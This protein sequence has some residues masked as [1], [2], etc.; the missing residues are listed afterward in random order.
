[1]GVTE[2]SALG[3]VLGERSAASLKRAF[4][5]TL[6]SD[7]LA[8]YPRR[9]AMRGELT[10]LQGTPL[11][12]PVSIVAEVVSVGERPMR[13]RR[14]SLLEVVIT[15]GTGLI[16]LTFFNQAWRKKDLHPG[17]RG[18]FAGKVGSYRG[19]KQLS[20]P[21]YELFPGDISGEESKK[22]AMTPIPLYPAT[23]TLAS[24]Q[25]SRAV[26]IVLDSLEPVPDPLPDDV[27]AGEGLMAKDRALRLIHQPESPDDWVGARDTLRFHE[28][29]ILQLALLQRRE[30]AR[31]QKTV[32]RVAGKLLAHFDAYTPF[33][34]TDG[35]LAVGEEI[36]R[37]LESGQPMHRLVHGEV[38]S[39]KT[40]VAIRGMLQVAQ[41]GGQSALLAPTEVLATQHFRSIHHTLGTEVASRVRPVLLTGSMSAAEKKKALFQVASG[42][43]LIVVGTHALL[44]DRVQFAD[45][46]LVI[47]DEQHRF[48]V[49]QRNTLRLKGAHPHVLVLTATPIPRTVAMTVFGDLDVSTISRVPEGRHPIDTHVVALDDHPDWYD[50]VWSRAREEIDR[51]RQ[52]FVVCPAIDSGDS[53]EES[54]LPPVEPDSEEAPRPPSVGV[55]QLQKELADMPALSGVTV[56]ILHG[57]LPSED[58]DSVMGGF[59]SGGIDLLVATT[60]IEVGVDVPNATM[61][62]IM[63]ADRFGISQLHQLRGRVGRGQHPGLCLLVT[64]QPAETVARSR[65]DAVHSTTNGFDLSQI[66]LE[67]RHEGDVLGVRQSGGRSSLKLL[68]VREDADVIDRARQMASALL[69]ESPDLASFPLLAEA[70]NQRLA[71]EDKEF[72]TKS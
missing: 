12:E 61:M 5:Y 62:I 40:L 63:D 55:V 36:S 6:V 69:A 25:I 38:G 45:L 9:Y 35:Q 43:S 71:L 28:A 22:W 54:T 66:D 64:R 24:W 44:A 65:L 1:V 60:V 14:G 7:L 32:P 42:Q 29:Y 10:S 59:Q 49:E 51:G 20:H 8:H 50:R 57:R 4:G 17:A 72:L 52:V 16:T 34:L 23:S 53:G 37:D 70:L 68:R 31:G 47:V 41:N 27:V 26:G 56:D 58:K 13:Q 2:H 18:I 30:E 67:L 33:T 21:D 15:D 39:G 11:G 48:G 3:E 46:G 19:G